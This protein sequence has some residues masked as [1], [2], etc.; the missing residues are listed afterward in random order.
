MKRRG[1]FVFLIMVLTAPSAPAGTS[2][3]VLTGLPKPEPYAYGTSGS[4]FFGILTSAGDSINNSLVE[5]QKDGT[6]STVCNTTIG[7]Y[8]QLA[9]FME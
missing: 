7:M 2:R 4:C 1:K 9:Y 5:I 6:L 3:T 8:G